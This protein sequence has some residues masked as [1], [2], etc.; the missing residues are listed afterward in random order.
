MVEKNKKADRTTLSE[1][2]SNN[3]NNLQIQK[4]RKVIG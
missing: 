2:D 4:Y 1:L 3:K